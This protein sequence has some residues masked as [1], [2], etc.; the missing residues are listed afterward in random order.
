MEKSMK[1]CSIENCG[2]QATSRTWCPAHYT[3]WQRHGNPLYKREFKK[4]EKCIVEGCERHQKSKGYCSTHYAKILR[5]GTLEIINF[6]PEW[7]RKNAET[8]MTELTRLDSTKDPR[9]RGYLAVNVVNDLKYK[10]RQ[11]G[12]EWSLTNVEAYQL[13]IKECN[14]CG[15]K[16]DWPKNRVG[17]DR[18]DNFKGYELANC[19]SCC[20]RC[21]SAKGTH[22]KKEFIDWIKTVYNRLES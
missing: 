11:R 6:G 19:V 9:M 14:Y 18:V 10:A 2:K 7:K 13:I 21:N 20:T 22:T 8:R 17:I 15:Y 5:T 16:P 4:P 3:M 12:L 1:V